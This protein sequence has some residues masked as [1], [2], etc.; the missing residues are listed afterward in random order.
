[1]LSSPEYYEQR[2]RVIAAK[3]WHVGGGVSYLMGCADLFVSIEK[4]LWGRDAHDGIAYTAGT[5]W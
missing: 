4:Y 5:T 1:M 2:D 3:Y